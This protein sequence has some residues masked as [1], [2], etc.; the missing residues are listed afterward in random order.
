MESDKPDIDGC[1]RGLCMPIVIYDPMGLI[2]RGHMYLD[3][4]TKEFRYDVGGRR[5]KRPTKRRTSPLP[6]TIYDKIRMIKKRDLF[7]N[8]RKVIFHRDRQRFFC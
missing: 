6:R 5:L 8:A 3:Y 1:G 4:T 2:P 7:D